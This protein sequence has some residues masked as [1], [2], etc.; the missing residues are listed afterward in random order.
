MSFKVRANHVRNFAKK[1]ITVTETVPVYTEDDYEIEYVVDDDSGEILEEKVL[2]ADAQPKATT[3]TKTAGVSTSAPKV[4]DPR[5]HAPLSM[6]KVC[7]ES[8]M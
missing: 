4:H 2:K 8:Y 7:S 1:N 6:R 3:V 5:H